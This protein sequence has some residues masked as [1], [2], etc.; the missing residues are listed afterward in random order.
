RRAAAAKS[1]G[2]PSPAATRAFR[3]RTPAT[4]P[5]DARAG[6]GRVRDHRRRLGSWPALG[7]GPRT[8]WW[9]SIGCYFMTTS[10]EIASASQPALRAPIPVS[11]S[12]TRTLCES[13]AE[14]CASSPR[15]AG[16]ASSTSC[17]ASTPYV[18]RPYARQP[19]SSQKESVPT[20]ELVLKWAGGGDACYRHIAGLATLRRGVLMRGALF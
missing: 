8:R 4:S 2:Q 12:E 5:L 14:T 16:S 6:P 11:V 17:S 13:N 19:A 15:H 9:S 10:T 18:Q 3:S 1:V 7:L 20:A